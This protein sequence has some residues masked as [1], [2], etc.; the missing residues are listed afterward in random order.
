MEERAQF[1]GLV[2][3]VAARDAVKVAVLG[4]GE[5][6]QYLQV[7]WYYMSL[8]RSGSR[9]RCCRGSGGNV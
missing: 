5:C 7:L 6:K 8:G 1:Q 4:K 9:S 2:D 3:R